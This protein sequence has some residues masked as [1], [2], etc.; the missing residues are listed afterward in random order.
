MKQIE[1]YFPH[2]LLLR[3]GVTVDDAELSLWRAV[4]RF[5]LDLSSVDEE[6]L[7]VPLSEGG[8]S[9]A[10]YAD[11]LYRVTLLYIDGV[12]KALRGEAPVEFERGWMTASGGLIS[13]PDGEP[14]AGRELTVLERDLRASTSALIDVVRRAVAGSAAEHVSHVNP[15][16]GPLT[17]LGCLQM[18]AVHAVHHV[19]KHLSLALA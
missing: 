15:Y 4:D 17:P 18:A 11:H 9:P 14:V 1:A 8:W 12:E 19:R 16:F 10:Q 13:P 3:Q 2:D 5:L 7:H 6:R